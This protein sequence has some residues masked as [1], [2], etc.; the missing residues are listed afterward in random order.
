[1]I[2]YVPENTALLPGVTSRW[3][4]LAEFIELIETVIDPLLIV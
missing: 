1:L 2:T 3:Y 4:P